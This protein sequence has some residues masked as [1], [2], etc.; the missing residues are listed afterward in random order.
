MQK[1][2]RRKRNRNCCQNG[3][4]SDGSINLCGRGI[5][6]TDFVQTG[7]MRCAEVPEEKEEKELLSKWSSFRPESHAVPQD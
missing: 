1:C 3:L 2:L 4:L 6:K 5:V 7:V